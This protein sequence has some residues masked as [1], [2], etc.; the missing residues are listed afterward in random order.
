MWIPSLQV[1]NTFAVNICDTFVQACS[2]HTN[3]SHVCANLRVQLTVH[4]N[5]PTSP[6]SLCSRRIPDMMDHRSTVEADQ[7]PFCGLDGRTTQMI[8]SGWMTMGGVARCIWTVSVDTCRWNYISMAWIHETCRYI[9]ATIACAVG[10]RLQESKS[11]SCSS[12]YQDVTKR[13]FRSDASSEPS[14]HVTSHC[15]RM[16]PMVPLVAPKPTKLWRHVDATNEG[17]HSYA[18]L[19]SEH[20]DWW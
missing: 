6:Q 16:R 1:D 18:R 17:V 15:L 7:T 10:I 4:R 3:P 12:C 20:C 9:A 2:Q 13:S 5:Q 19:S 11:Q 8:R 14:G